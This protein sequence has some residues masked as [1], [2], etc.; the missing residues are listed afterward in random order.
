MVGVGVVAAL[1]CCE[2]RANNLLID[3]VILHHSDL[4]HEELSDR[5]QGVVLSVFV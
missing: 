4:I 1:H 5:Q 2:V 3:A